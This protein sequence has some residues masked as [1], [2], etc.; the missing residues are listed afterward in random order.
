M[1][2]PSPGSTE[3]QRAELEQHA[4][5]ELAANGLLQNGRLDEEFLQ[6][7]RT[8]DRPTVEFYGWVDLHANG[9]ASVL[10]ASN[11]Y[12]SVRAVLVNNT[13]FHIE[14]L[15][16]N[17]DLAAAATAVMPPLQPGAG[18]ANAPL[19]VLESAMD[20][21]AY[22]ATQDD[23]LGWRAQAQEQKDRRQAAQ[24][25][26]IQQLPR[27]GGGMFYTAARDRLGRRRRAAQWISY[28]DTQDGRWLVL[29][30]QV[31]PQAETWVSCVPGTPQAAAERLHHLAADGAQR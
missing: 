17:V 10:A 6:D 5:Q 8:L 15:P 1:T 12:T 27:I 11:G 22:Q 31:P 18:A 14:P 19:A 30:Q 26:A 29:Q 13:E 21:N 28:L 16:G 24:V 23:V 7:I 3:E 2:V 25:L 4:H 20:P 9:K